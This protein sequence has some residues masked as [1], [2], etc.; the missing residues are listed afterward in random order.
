MKHNALYNIDQETKIVVVT[1]ELGA[2]IIKHKDTMLV[3]KLLAPCT[4][5]HKTLKTCERRDADSVNQIA[6]TSRKNTVIHNYFYRGSL[7]VSDQKIII[8]K[9]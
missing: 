4:V 3:R 5:S 8:Y 9:K 2:L 1:T 6:F 7:R